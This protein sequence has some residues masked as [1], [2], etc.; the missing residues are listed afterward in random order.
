MTT[1]LMVFA[2]VLMALLLFFFLYIPWGMCWGAT[3]EECVMQMEGDRYL[4]EESSD[5]LV[6]TRAISI[7]K[8]PETVWPW[9]AQ[10]GRGAGWYSIDLLDNAGK[11][12]ARHIVSWIPAPQI[13]DASPIGYLCY[14]DSGRE[15]VWRSGDSQFLGSVVRM[16]MDF[17]VIPKKEGS[18]L[19]VRISS[20]AKGI[21]ARIVKWIFIFIDTIMARRQLLGIKE[22]VELYGAR[23]K[24]HKEPENGSR[25]Q[26][27]S[28]KII[29]ASGETAGTQEEDKALYWHQAAV[30]DGVIKTGKSHDY[31]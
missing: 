21:S 31:E 19:I 14:Q 26:Y 28:Y 16:V 2:F 8:P 29:Y 22:R 1:L 15:L 13:G 23:S 12:S 11:R 24:N 25:D 10:L 4:D 5:R 3:D 30:K 17:K 20:D 18:R 7:S 6:M 27:Q 9:L